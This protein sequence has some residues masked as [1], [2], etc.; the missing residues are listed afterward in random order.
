MQNIPQNIGHGCLLNAKHGGTGIPRI[1]A[2]AI[3][4]KL[5]LSM[6]IILL[7]ALVGGDWAVQN[8]LAASPG[9][10]NLTLSGPQPAT[11][12][13]IAKSKQPFTGIKIQLANPG[14]GRAEARLRFFIHSVGVD[15][16][17][18]QAGGIKVAVQE[19]NAW[20]SLPVEPID[21]G[22]MGAIGA[23]GSGHKDMHRRGGFALPAKLHKTLQLRITFGSPGTYQV[24]AALSPDNGNKIL[25]TPSFIT[26]EAL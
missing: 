7:V 24:V 15:H 26:V 9:L 13:Q 11:N 25:A 4:K 14:A 20:V 19:G 5:S 3:L 10:L 2:N 22:V 6:G 1:A 21:G 17:E 12:R 8:A 16:H 23:A 18:V